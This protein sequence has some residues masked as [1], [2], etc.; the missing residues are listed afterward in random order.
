[1]SSENR[2]HQWAHGADMVVGQL[3][4][5]GVK[6]IFGIPRCQNR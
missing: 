4:A 6:Q 3:E 1:M 2:T 5:Q